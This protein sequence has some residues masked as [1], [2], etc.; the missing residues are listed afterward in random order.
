NDGR[1]YVLR[2]LLRRAVRHGMRLG[3][4]EPFLCRLLPL[5]DEAMAGHYP[6]LAA[7]RAASEATLKAEEEKFLATV[8][9]GSSR[10]QE[11][12]EEA[13]K[14]GARELPGPVVFRLYDTYGLPIQLLQEIVE[15][16]KFGLDRAGFDAELDKQRDRSRAATGTQQNLALDAQKVLENSLAG[17]GPT[18]FLGYER[19]SIEGVRPLAVVSHATNGAE[20]NEESE[21]I[22]MS[23]SISKGEKG[24]VVF[25]RT[26]FYAESGGQ[27][28]DRGE[29][30]WDGGRARV[31]D[32]RKDSTG[33]ILH[34]VETVEGSLNESSPSMKLF[35]SAEHRLATQRNHTATHL[36]HAALR[37]VLGEGVRQAGSLVAPDHLRF[38]FTYGKPVT[39]VERAEI[40]RI[41]NDWVLRAVPTVI[42]PDRPVAEALA[43]GAMALFGEK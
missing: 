30:T 2:R 28:G 9:T 21:A 33:R 8:A 40:E 4:A 16:E 6:E 23:N 43:A 29:L 31:F 13:K 41:V 26:V 34:L 18:E 35:V 5:V 14:D 24:V 12:I 17:T 27:V 38:D 42:T 3:F 22:E 39:A 19:L 7:T 20:S 11:A 36:L 25:G 10:V 1:G 15:E 32:T 37:Q